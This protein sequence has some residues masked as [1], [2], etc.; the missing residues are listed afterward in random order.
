MD[1]VVDPHPYPPRT[2][3]WRNA[4]SYRTFSLLPL[5][6]IKIILNCKGKLIQEYLL[7]V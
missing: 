2:P 4:M 5:L 1:G 3:V 7:D 6:R